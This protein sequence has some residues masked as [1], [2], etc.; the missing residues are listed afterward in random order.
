MRV[1]VLLF[2]ARTE[3][4]G[5]HTIQIGS[6]N[7]VLMFKSE[8]D[9]IRFGLMLEAQDFLT[10]TVE[11]FESEEIEEFCREAGYD[12]ELIEEDMLAVPPET[13]V[14][15]TEWNAEGKPSSAA[16]ASEMSDLDAIRRRLEGLL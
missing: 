13:N 2:N 4:E 8:D 6:R 1:Y 3:N 14:E 12:A 5:I 15:Q 7:K 11:E 9:A 16:E 10:P